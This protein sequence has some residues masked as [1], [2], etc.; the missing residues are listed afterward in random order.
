M[1]IPVGTIVSG[2]MALLELAAKWKA[3]GAD[4][5]PD[6][7]VDAALDSMAASDDRLSE[8]IKRHEGAS[9]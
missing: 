2:G 1:P 8:A 7:E 3:A 9:E 5:V 4:E 6:A